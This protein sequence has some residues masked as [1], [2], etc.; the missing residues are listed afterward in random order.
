MAASRTAP[1]RRP[2]EES[3]LAL[4]P[5]PV[6]SPAEET[7][8]E[9]GAV[10]TK[11]KRA[12]TAA[13]PRP[14]PA[15]AGG[16][17]A[18]TPR[19][20]AVSRDTVRQRRFPNA[21]SGAAR[22]RRLPRPWPRRTERTSSAQRRRRSAR[23]VAAACREAQEVVAAP[24]RTHAG[25]CYTREVAPQRSPTAYRAEEAEG[26]AIAVDTD[27]GAAA[28]GGLRARTRRVAR[29]LEPPSPGAARLGDGRG[30]SR[31][32]P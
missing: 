14:R 27:A 1:R 32:T 7:V 30:V 3:D 25:W 17:R 20:G 12:P 29:R 23:A 5:Q 28:Q 13:P 21:P 9:E 2:A 8:V 22:R 18:P 19:A 15:R 6:M 16:S 4:L 11:K 31:R 24:S 26:G 10:K